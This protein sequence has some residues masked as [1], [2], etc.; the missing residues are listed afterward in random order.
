VVSPSTSII[1]SAPSGGLGLDAA[2][3]P[4]TVSTIHLLTI[5][6]GLI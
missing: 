5:F 2:V 4:L 1:K 6:S 3:S